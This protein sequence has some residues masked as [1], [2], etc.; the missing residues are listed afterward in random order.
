MRAQ[1]PEQMYK[2]AEYIPI[3]TSILAFIFAFE[4]L[5]MY[6]KN[7][8]KFLLWWTIWLI[9]FGLGTMSEGINSIFGWDEINFRFWY[10]CG[11]LL[12][13]FPLAQG[14]I[15]LLMSE[16]YGDISSLIGVIFI[17]LG[18]SFVMISPIEILEDFNGKLNGDVLAWQW[19]RNFSL[20]VNA[21]S[22]LI[23]FGGAVYS[24]N[25]YFGQ[26]N[27]ESKFIACLY[28]SFGVILPGIGGF[29]M[30]IGYMYVLY[31]TEFIAL[32]LIYQGYRIF[33]KG[34]ATQ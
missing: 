21:Y 14:T 1:C 27:K 15:Y 13:A 18:A 32:L 4:V 30:R 6:R 29:Y 9:C 3:F 24:A 17:A 22:S 8:K 28:I 23:V 5:R 11:A 20:I 16:K 34:E 26:I 12:G 25:Q 19:T 33:M 2:F 31:I 7:R 10:I